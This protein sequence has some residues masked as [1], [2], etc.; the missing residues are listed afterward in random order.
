MLSIAMSTTDLVYQ[1]CVFTKWEKPS[2]DVIWG[3][4]KFATMVLHQ[5]VDS[6]S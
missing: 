3:L 2:V 5:E 6:K 1:C 4:G